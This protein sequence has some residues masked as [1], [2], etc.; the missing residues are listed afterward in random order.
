MN[1]NTVIFDMDG[2]LIDSEP[3]WQEAAVEVL[4]QFD[5]ALTM[6]QYHLTTGLRTK[7]WIEHWF[8]HFAIDMSHANS[9]GEAIVNKAIQKIKENGKAMPGVHHILSYFKENNFKIGLATSSPPPLIEIVVDK[10]KIRDFFQAWSSADILPHS[11]PHPEVYMNCAEKLGSSPLECICFE[12]S[13][14]GMISAKA[15]RMKCVV[16]P[17]PELYHEAKWGAA[18]L[19]LKNLNEWKGEWVES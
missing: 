14:N 13:F 1:L 10:L 17:T 6:D 8:Q 5:I 12:D 11:K 3:Y 19:K 2:L 4:D 7:E 18:D 16:V 15:A 9:T